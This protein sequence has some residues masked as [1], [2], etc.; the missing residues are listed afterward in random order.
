[1]AREQQETHGG[2]TFGL[3]ES[4]TRVGRNT[5]LFGNGLNLL[6]KKLQFGL[7]SKLVGN[8]FIF[9]F[10]VKDKLAFITLG[11]LDSS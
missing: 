9:T 4:E 8:L 1:M 6:L 10:V 11:G 2:D 3:N 5:S 7:G